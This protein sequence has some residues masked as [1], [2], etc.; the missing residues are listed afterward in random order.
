MFLR[1][2]RDLNRDV[3]VDFCISSVLQNDRCKKHSTCEVF[4]TRPSSTFP[5]FVEIGTCRC[6]FASMI[7]FTFLIFEQFISSH[8]DGS[9]GKTPCKK[10]MLSH[11][12]HAFVYFSYFQLNFS[13]WQ[14]RT[15]T[16]PYACYCNKLRGSTLTNNFSLRV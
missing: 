3:E 14:H 12:Q 16:C 1:T 8:L 4:K 6:Q 7:L 5:A 10:N 2:V 11:C 13:R 15:T 9:T